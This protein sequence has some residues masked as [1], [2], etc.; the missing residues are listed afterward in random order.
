MLPRW[1]QEAPRCSKMFQ[2]G[3]K[4]LRRWP[5]DAPRGSQ[6][7]PKMP[8]EASK[9][10][11][12]GPKMRTQRVSWSK[13]AP[14]MAPR[15]PKRLPRW[16]QEAPRC[17]K[18]LQDRPKMLPRW[19][20]GAPRGPQDIFHIHRKTSIGRHPLCHDGLQNSIINMFTQMKKTEGGGGESPPWASSIKIYEKINQDD[21][22][23]TCSKPVK[24]CMY[25][26]RSILVYPIFYIFICFIIYI[27]MYAYIHVYIYIYTR[28]DLC[29]YMHSFTG[30]E[31]VVFAS[32]Y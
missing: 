12:G 8:Q 3:P 17:S 7:G 14:K 23:T 22:K 21:S 31:Q 10:G 2:D 6:D 5:Q 25:M 11:P 30:F 4:M 32:F 27:Y 29:T 13:L 28:V 15:R 24:L 26:H 16:A 18:M 1:V 20:Q 9:M 19:P